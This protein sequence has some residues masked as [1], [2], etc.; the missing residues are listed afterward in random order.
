M[1][2]LKTYEELS[3]ENES[4]GGVG[5]WKHQITQ[6]NNW[7]IYVQNNPYAKAVLNTVLNNQGGWASDRQW[8]I[9]Q[10]AKRGDK[11]PYHPKN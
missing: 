1:D 5:K 9:L 2:R 8:E 6:P 3:N 7:K 4:P 10:R 11:S